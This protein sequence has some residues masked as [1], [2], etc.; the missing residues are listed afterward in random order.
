MHLKKQRSVCCNA[1]KIWRT[2]SFGVDS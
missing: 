2:R 1:N